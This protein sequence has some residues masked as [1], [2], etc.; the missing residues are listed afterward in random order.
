MSVK[1]A[2]SRL[3]RALV[4]ALLLILAIPV[5]LIAILATETGSGWLLSRADELARPLGIELSIERSRGSLLRRLELD[6]VTF[7]G[8]GT[9]LELGHLLLQWQPRGLLE[10][11]LHIEALELSDLRVVPPVPVET[12]ATAP[13]I[14]DLVLPIAVQ[15]DRFLLERLEI[16]QGEG[17]LDINRVALAAVFDR[18]GLRVR[19]LDFEGQGARLEGALSMQAAAPHMLAGEIAA[20]LDQALVGADIGDVAATALLTGPALAPVVELRLSAPADVNLRAELQLEQPEPGFDVVAAWPQLQWPLRGSAAV[21]SQA[22][23]LTLRGTG[24]DYRLE[25]RT[26][27]SGDGIP[28]SR[29]D[30]LAQ[31]DLQ[32]I[33][34][35][36]LEVATLDGR[37]RADGSVHWDQ[38]TR[39]HFDLLVDR[40]NPGLYEPQLPGQ[41]SG[42]LSVTGAVGNT[43]ADAL[44]VQLRIEELNGQLREHAVGASGELD[45]RRGQL[46]ARALQLTSGPNSLYL[47][48]R[49]D[50]RLDLSFDIK[51]PDLVSL[52][53]GLSGRLEGAG[54]LRGTPQAP[55][56]AAKLNGQSVGYGQTRAQDIDLDIDW[57]EHGGKG[58]LRLSGLAAGGVQIPELSADLEGTP[59]SHRLKLDALV[60]EFTVGLAAE[61]GLQ[62]QTW[63][64]QL[65]GLQLSE[66]RLGEWRLGAPARLRLGQTAASSG[67]LCLVRAA[68]RVCAE[69]AWD[70]AKGLDFAASLADLDLAVL[71]PYLPDEAAVE[72]TVG[73]RFDVSGS[74]ARPRVIFELRPSDGL[75]R[76]E[77]DLQP[78]ELAY[79]NARVAGRFENDAGTVDLNFE[80]GPKGR[81]QGRLLVGADKAGQRSIGGE[82]A[83]D[84]PDLALVA[85]FV[86]ALAQVEG[87]LRLDTKL[88]GTL[89]APR[90]Q[91][92]L[93][94]MDAQA[95]VPEAGIALTDIELTVR[96]DGR[97]PLG[98]QGQVASGE[99][100]LTIAGKV[101]VSAPT[102]PAVDLS[103]KGENFQAVQLPEATVQVSPDLRL[104]GKGP[105]H[106]S[107]KLLIPRAAIELEEVPTGTVNV[108][109]DEI[110][111]GEETTQA[112][113]TGTQNLTARVRVELGE[114][115]TFK[116]FG[117]KTSLEGR[118]DAAVDEQGTRVDGKIELRDGQYKAYG[119]DLTVERGRLLFVGPP[120]NP[121]VDLRAVRESRDGRVKAYLAMSG[122]LSKPRPRI[123]TEPSLPEAEALAYLL[124]GRGLDSASQEEGA[125][126][127]GAALS[128]G[129]STAEPLIQQ[130][131]L[132]EVRVEEGT[133][134]AE[135]TS[136]IL[137]KYLNPDLYVGYSQGLFNP[138][139]A[140]LLRL[141]LSEQVEVESR[142][143]NEQS[144][145]LFYRLEHD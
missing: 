6:G 65:K 31:G 75:I 1:R 102:G 94:I 61:G 132:D 14:P 51:A 41:I 118:L 53:P 82:V 79:R 139:G 4:L 42:R 119:Q 103:V 29:V 81:A 134:G 64:G 105:Y 121:G 145:D 143:G 123:Y 101:D 71:A 25:L 2:F 113:Q 54:R 93:Q 15:L 114:H 107:G 69:G 56:L 128:L 85:G 11:R 131:G 125:N 34:L 16:E 37:L 116:G 130:M 72:G 99:G 17:R 76:V 108:S 27:I 28:A 39:W 78:F 48:G 126:I 98:V 33:R 49:A 50:E 32:G 43:D 10:R 97:A 26:G 133:G 46:H 111:V 129:L 142:S 3:L 36:P 18:D 92:A 62:Q 23:Q 52:Y 120:G 63:E 38:G 5:V 13:E 59:E 124:T 20:Q 141:R 140:V 68:T 83:V 110:V 109:D 74:A 135:S 144:V 24:S 90:V 100:R 117:L 66:P 84:F 55:A 96:G 30:L 57:Q 58:R 86:P 22:G 112:R 106:L 70:A 104:Q 80:L 122:P 60:E 21:T 7:E 87:R 88:G 115:V 67:P 91:G 19:D 8:V 9:R 47:D 44:S 35:Q 77:Q 138:E 95:Q 12:E 127:A 45:Y 137:G 40:I 89:A 136:V 73:A